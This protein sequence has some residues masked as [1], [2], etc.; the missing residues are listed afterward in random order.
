MKEQREDRDVL[1]CTNEP[2]NE[3]HEL[4]RRAGKSGLS[5]RE[6]E[7]LRQLE[8]NLDQCWDLLGQRRALREAGYHPDEAKVRDEKTV[9]RC[10]Q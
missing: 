3:E 7:W 1:G 6:H 10:L 5:V 9:E 2:V 4:Y 8:A